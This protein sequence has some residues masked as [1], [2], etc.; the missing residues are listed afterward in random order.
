MAELHIRGWLT[1]DEDGII[2]LSDNNPSECEYSWERYGESIIRK[3]E[4]FADEYGVLGEHHKG[5]GG[6][7]AYI[8]DCN[9]RVYFTDKECELE[10]AML[11][12]DVLMFGGDI[13]TRI[14]LCGYSEYTIEGL[15]LIEFS[16]G[17]HNLD[18][19]FRS[20]YGEYCH[21]IIEC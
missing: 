4:N 15:D 8:D 14:D 9:L 20:H 18:G 16:I 1:S 13:K 12:L 6:R 2:A 17:G 19:E 3:I 5:L 11:T 10:E 7:K 21:I